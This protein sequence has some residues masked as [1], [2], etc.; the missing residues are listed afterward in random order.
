MEA[1]DYCIVVEGELG[2]RYAV[3]FYPMRL[4]AHG[5]ITEITG[6]I[7]DQAQLRRVLHKVSELG[8]S[9]VSARPVGAEMHR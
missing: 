5:G 8:L 6:T 9:L 3:A 1:R 7:E 2:A 4:A